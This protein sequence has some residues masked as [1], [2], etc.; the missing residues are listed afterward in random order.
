MKQP[1]KIVP[2]KLPSHDGKVTAEKKMVLS[3]IK[4]IRVEIEII[5]AIFSDISKQQVNF[6]LLL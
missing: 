4:G 1:L 5:V 3:L 6:H 2:R